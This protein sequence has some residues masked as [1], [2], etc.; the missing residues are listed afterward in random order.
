M[1]KFLKLKP[2]LSKVLNKDFLKSLDVSFSDD[3]VSSKET[4]K[5]KPERSPIR[6][7]R[8]KVPGLAGSSAAHNRELNYEVGDPS[9]GPPTDAAGDNASMHITGD[10]L[11]EEDEDSLKGVDAALGNALN[12]SSLFSDENAGEEG[13][14]YEDAESDCDLEIIGAPPP[15]KW[16]PPKKF[17]EWFL[18][19]ADIEIKK[20]DLD[21]IKETFKSSE[22]LSSDFSPPLFPP[23]IWN[24][25]Q[26]SSS[27]S[28]RLKYIYKAQENMYLALKPLLSALSSVPKENRKEIST[29]IQ[30]ICSSNLTLNRY[31]RTTISPN[32]KKDLRKQILNLPVTHDSLF[33]KN[34]SQST[35]S[36][37]KEQSAIEKVIEKR[38]VQQ[39][40]TF[41]QR[42][43]PPQ[44]SKQP[45]R[46]GPSR[47]YSRG[48]RGNTRGR[49]RGR[50]SRTPAQKSQ[51]TDSAS[52]PGTSSSL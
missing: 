44:S 30:L 45:F 4:S 7:K 18:K 38:S 46:N 32:L 29:A 8:V 19:V 20:E 25:I 31:R 26:T 28:F 5:R 27:D 9:G 51:A 14:D 17:M 43:N 49:N 23:S 16:T 35:D 10:P 15:A 6:V 40:L 22:E 13:N 34:F 41:Q 11:V 37:I 12:E 3:E 39:R 21:N 48:Y 24:S 1:E 2:F 52:K 36:L 50:G 33:G 42:G 47:G